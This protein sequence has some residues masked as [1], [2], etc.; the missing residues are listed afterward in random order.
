MREIAYVCGAR[1]ISSPALLL[2]GVAMVGWAPP[3]DGLME[4]TRPPKL[5]VDDFIDGRVD[6]NAKIVSKIKASKD[7]AL[8]E[9]TFK[10]TMDEVERGVLRG[11]YTSTSE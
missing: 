4:R 8:D 7:N 9:V 1:D 5:S 10:K 2:I 3:A 11:P 6:R